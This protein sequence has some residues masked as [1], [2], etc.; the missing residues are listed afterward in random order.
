MTD[1]F[2][3]PPTRRDE[4][5]YL[6]LRDLS[7]RLGISRTSAWRLVR[8]GYIQSYRFLGVVRVRLEDVEAFEARCRSKAT[9]ALPTARKRAFKAADFAEMARR[10]AV[11][12]ISKRAWR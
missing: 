9:T 11:A 12:T 5:R 3:D 2:L 1:R 4:P 8:R 6:S 10:H 7:E